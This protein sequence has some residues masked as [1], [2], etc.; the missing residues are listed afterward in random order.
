MLGYAKQKGYAFMF[1]NHVYGI[2]LGSNM[3]KIYSQ[4]S[5]EILKEKN[6]IADGIAILST[7]R[8][9]CSFG[10][11]GCFTLSRLCNR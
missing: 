3:I 1:K 9:I 10:K 2:D 4:N 5:N 8:S 7:V 11:N 6:M